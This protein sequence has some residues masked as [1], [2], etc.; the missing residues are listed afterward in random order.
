MLAGGRARARQTQAQMYP[1][2]YELRAARASLRHRPHGLPA[3]RPNSS[4]SG[5]S[6]E[7]RAG[8]GS[9][10]CSA[11]L[12]AL[13]ARLALLA[14]CSRPTRPTRSS[15]SQLAQVQPD[16]RPTTMA[17]RQVCA[18]GGFSI[19]AQSSFIIVATRNLSACPYPAR[20]PAVSSSFGNSAGRPA[21]PDRSRSR[22][23]AFAPFRTLI[24]HGHHHHHHPGRARARAPFFRFFSD[25][26]WSLFITLSVRCL[27]AVRD[28][29]YGS[30][31]C[32][33]SF[34]PGNL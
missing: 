30:L 17:I 14:F 12:L 4:A 10:L 5:L 15:H 13:L 20:R 3:P 11:L 9:L 31:G 2:R 28:N 29:N 16:P 23:R 18:S 1:S 21:W 6:S 26:K 22:A 32:D 33:N 27:Y 25:T 19:A 24:D 8:L 34:T 7:L